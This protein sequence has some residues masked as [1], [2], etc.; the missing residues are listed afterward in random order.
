MQRILSRFGWC[1]ALALAT[2]CG[3]S[4]DSGGASGS[5]GSGGSGA[6]KLAAAT[7]TGPVS[8][9]DESRDLSS[10]SSDESQ[11]YCKDIGSYN[12]TTLDQ[13]QAKKVSCAIVALL[14]LSF[15]GPSADSQQ[16]CQN[17]FTQCINQPAPNTTDDGCTHTKINT[18]MGVTVGQYD[19]CV[20]EQIGLS[21]VAYSDFASLPV[22][23]ICTPASS[24]AGG[25]S[26]GTSSGNGGLPPSCLPIDAKCPQLFESSSTTN[27]G[28]GGAGGS[29]GSGQAGSGA[30]GGGNAGSGGAKAGSGGAAAGSGGASGGAA[31][32]GG[33]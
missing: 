22:A 3:N 25:A 9:T 10:L 1:F 14:T 18:C 27:T 30:A 5:S 7:P 15:G 12:K 19:V 28:D 33:G 11:K 21:R 2:G 8:T 20:R 4:S 32:K 23:Q 29:A 17:A 16:A 31:G 13:E 6:E 24:G 26:T